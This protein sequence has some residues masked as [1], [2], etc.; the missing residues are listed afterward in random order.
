MIAEIYA[1]SVI[2]PNIPAWHYLCMD[3]MARIRTEKGLSQA[4][5]AEMVGANQATIS[6][7]EKGIGNPTLSMINRIAKALGVHPSALFGLDPLRERALR[8][9]DGIDDQARREAAIIVLESMAG[10]QD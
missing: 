10:K 7:I 9:I 4:Q 8:A 5:V 3:N 2:A 1:Q 6:K